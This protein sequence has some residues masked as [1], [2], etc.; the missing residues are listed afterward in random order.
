MNRR[1]VEKAW[2]ELPKGVTENFLLRRVVKLP[3]MLLVMPPMDSTV[4]DFKTWPSSDFRG[5]PEIQADIV[6]YPELE[7]F[8][9]FEQAGGGVKPKK[10]IHAPG[11]IGRVK[12]VLYK[13][14]PSRALRFGLSE[15]Q[16]NF[17]TSGEN[18]LPRRLANHYKKWRFEALKHVVELCKSTGVAVL[19]HREALYYTHD[20]AEKGGR[21]VLHDYLEKKAREAGLNFVEQR[22]DF[23]LTP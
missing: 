7:H 12:L 2:R 20:K 1:F 19:V 14:L 16:H 9:H 5:S 21:A 11:S 22:G 23:L 10:T 18:P 8:V 3:R 15:I 13:H 4:T 6:A 17:R